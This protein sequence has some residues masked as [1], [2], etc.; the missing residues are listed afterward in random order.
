[1]LSKLVQE[2]NVH[3][4]RFDSEFDGVMALEAL[5]NLFDVYL[6]PVRTNFRCET[7]CFRKHN[8][9]LIGTSPYVLHKVWLVLELNASIR[10][11]S[12]HILLTRTHFE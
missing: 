11:A 5:T 3:L 7:A 2:G 6:H 1:M 10:I 12:L 9:W 8:T 4:Q